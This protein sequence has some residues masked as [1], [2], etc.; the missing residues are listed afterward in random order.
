MMVELTNGY[1][2]IDRTPLLGNTGV[3]AKIRDCSNCMHEI[4]DWDRLQ[5]IKQQI[6]DRVPVDKQK[7]EYCKRLAKNKD[8]KWQKSRDK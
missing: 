6:R 1:P 4:K 2:Q 3:C 5:F 8:C 7:D